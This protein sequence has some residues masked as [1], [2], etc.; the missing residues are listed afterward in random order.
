MGSLAITGDSE[1]AFQKAI[2]FLTPTTRDCPNIIHL[3]YQLSRDVA[4]PGSALRSG[5]RG[6]GFESRHPDTTKKAPDFMDQGL[7]YVFSRPATNSFS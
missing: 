7:F 4:Q 3:Q 5:R 2:F 6:R 1:I